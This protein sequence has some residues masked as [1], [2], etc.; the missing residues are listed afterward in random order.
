MTEHKLAVAAY[1][2]PLTPIQH[3]SDIPIF[4]LIPI[5]PDEWEYTFIIIIIL[6]GDVGILLRPDF[7]S[8]GNLISSDARVSNA[9]MYE[10]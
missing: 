4:L 2:V 8:Q 7:K 1:S 5:N 3:Y 10:E 6:N 9:L